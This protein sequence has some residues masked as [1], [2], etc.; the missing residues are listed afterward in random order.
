VGTLR[1]YTRPEI[2]M[3]SKKITCEGGEITTYPFVTGGSGYVKYEWFGPN[4]YYSTDERITIQNIKTGQ[5]GIYTLIVTDT[6]NCTDSFDVKVIVNKNPQIAFAGLDTLFAQPGFVL[7]AGS[8]YENYL[9]N[10]GDT[11][12]AITVNDE[13]Q[14]WVTVT[15]EESCQAKDTVMV[16]WGGQPFYLPNAFTPNGDGL[17]DEFKPVQRY[18]FVKTYHLYIY[19]RWGQLIFETT[20]INT[21]WDGTFKGEPV[22]QGTYVY[23]IVYT[24]SSTGNKLQSVAG[25]VTLVR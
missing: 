13:G 10:T 15:S 5:A 12:D 8:G 24:A 22:E 7:E 14:Y 3:A 17:N 20:D 9:W 25:N 6:I 4:N 18:D 19:N 1:V 11:T 21:G 23:K 2:S 16:F